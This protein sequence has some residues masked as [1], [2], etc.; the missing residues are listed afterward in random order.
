VIDLF[1]QSEGISDKHFLLGEIVRE[2]Y[3][4]FGTASVP[5]LLKLEPNHIVSVPPKIRVELDEPLSQN[6]LES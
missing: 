3:E 1:V 2:Y 6:E 5:P 4:L